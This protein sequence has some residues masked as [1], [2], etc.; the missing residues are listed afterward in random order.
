M[1]SVYGRKE[2]GIIRR[3]SEPVTGTVR[4]WLICRWPGDGYRTYALYGDEIGWDWLT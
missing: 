2:Y 3:P 1:L 4:M